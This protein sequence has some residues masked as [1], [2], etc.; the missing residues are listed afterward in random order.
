MTDV[1]DRPIA[2]GLPEPVLR[3]TL[4]IDY[5]CCNFGRF[6]L[7]PVLAI[8]LA[9][10]A[11]GANWLT[12][13]LGLF[14]FMVFAGLSAVLVTRWLPRFPYVTTMAGSMVVSAVGFGLLPFIHGPGP[15]LALLFLA[16][17]GISVHGVLARVL[18]AE[19]VASEPGR[20]NV[21]SIQQI[22]TNTAAALGP[23]IAG[24]LYVSGHAG[25]LL[26][27]VSAAYV[28][29]GVSLVAGLPRHL[30]PPR[31]VAR[32]SGGGLAAGLRLLRDPECR[33]ASIVTAVGAFAYGQFY[34]AFALL[35]AL[36]I[37]ASLL[38]GALLAGPPVAIVVLQ[39]V[40]TFTANRW[41]RAGVPPLTI[42]A[43]AVLVFGAAIVLLGVGL[44]V[45]L[46]SVVAMTIWAFAEMLFTPT[47]SIVFNRITSVSRLAASNLQGVAWTTGEALGSLCGGA[48]FLVCYQHGTANLYWLVLAAVTLAGAVP[49]LI[50]R[51]TA[52]PSPAAA[53]Q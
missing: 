42:L 11:G 13:G 32:R 26:L 14:G 12:T 8:M 53:T 34:S 23:F 47:V 45:V 28:C 15:T 25:P 43:G 46:S 3:R 4:G 2:T 33:R 18:I 24:A 35:V 40:V 49:Y 44:P 16:G 17:F 51:R 10:Q 5:L 39:A 27:F 6:S 48:V 37:D 1:T 7:M 52:E 41:L 20:N 31:T 38:R 9:R 30:R 29:A 19:H 21:Y 50:G 22:A 36:A